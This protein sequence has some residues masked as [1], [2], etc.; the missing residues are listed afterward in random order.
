MNFDDIDQMERYVAIAEAALR[1][2]SNAQS[3]TAAE[4]IVSKS[5]EDTLIEKLRT[6]TAHLVR[7]RD[8]LNA[9]NRDGDP[10]LIG[11]VRGHLDRKTTGYNEL[12]ATVRVELVELT[13][14]RINAH[15]DVALRREV[16]DAA[17]DAAVESASQL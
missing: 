15:V 13:K 9:A 4:T 6:A 14:A 12:Y 8:M 7:A 10:D 5:R 16:L 3:I 11:L 1:D 17:C 2:L